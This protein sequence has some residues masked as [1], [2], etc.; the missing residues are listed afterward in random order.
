MLNSGSGL[1]SDALSMM[2]LLGSG[3][4][5]DLGFEK[6]ELGPSVHLALHQLGLRDLSL[7]LTI[8]PGL[9]DGSADGGFILLDAGG[10]GCN[11]AVLAS[12]IQGSRWVPVFF[13]IMVWNLSTSLRVSAKARTPVSMAATMMDKIAVLKQ[14]MQRLAALETEMLQTPDQQISLTDPDAR[15]MATSGRGTGMVGYNVQT[16]VETKHHLIVAHEVIQ[17]SLI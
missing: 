4:V 7:R 10:K 12:P 6:I 3:C 13:R 16:A 17:T 15:S 2:I 1:G 9:G 5:E 8:G 14:E 11:Q